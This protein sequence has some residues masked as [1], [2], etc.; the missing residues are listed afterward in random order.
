M[1]TRWKIRLYD[2]PREYPLSGILDSFARH[3]ALRSWKWRSKVPVLLLA[4]GD[5]EF[6]CPSCGAWWP[7]R[8]APPA[9]PQEPNGRPVMAVFDSR[10]RIEIRPKSM[11]VVCP[12][13]LAQELG[14]P[15]PET[16]CDGGRFLVSGG[17]MRLVG[18]DRADRV[19]I[20]V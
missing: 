4:D 9:A 14:R 10:G 8:R 16:H 7:A 17:V 19:P 5:I 2:D 1:R 18:S 11:H 12:A 6:N 13:W 3:R 15:Y 20:L